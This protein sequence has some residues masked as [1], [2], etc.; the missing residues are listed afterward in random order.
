MLRTKKEKIFLSKLYAQASSLASDI[1]KLRDAFPA[2]PNKK[3]LKIHKAT[4][5]KEPSKG[6]KIQTTTKGPSRKQAIILIPSQ[7]MVTIMNNAGFHISSINS[8]LKGIK[9]TLR[10]EFI[11]P[12][13]EGLI[14]TTNNVPVANNLSTM[15]RYIKSIEGINQNKVSTPRLP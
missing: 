7:Y 14:I 1:L 9:F 12:S 11:R 3:I 13:A 4:L 8:Q 6:R 2:L 10:A 5:S 15:E